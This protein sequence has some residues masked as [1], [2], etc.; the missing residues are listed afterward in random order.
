MK[1]ESF[2][3]FQLDVLREIGNIGAG[4]AATALSKLIS[5]EIDMQ[6]PQ[7][8]I[9]SFDEIADVVGG[10]EALVV[11]VFLRVLGDVPASM[12]FII[13]IESAKNLMKELLGMETK[14]EGSFDDMELSMLNEIGNILAGS[15]LSSLADFTNLNMQPSVPA[16]AIDMAGAILSYGL[17]EVGYSG[18]FALTIDTAFFQGNEEISGHFFLIPDPDAFS[19]LFQALGV[20]FE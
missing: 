11:C 17:L 6:I 5:K 8:N 20:P 13:S 15:Y 7:V 2:G 12:F 16:V 1:F 4:N 10:A 3:D 18:D 14:E 19:R 9:I